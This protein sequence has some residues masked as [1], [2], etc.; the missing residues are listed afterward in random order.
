[1]LIKI[2]EGTSLDSLPTK[3]E[4][5]T[6]FLRY[7]YPDVYDRGDVTE[8]NGNKITVDFADTIREFTL[9]EVTLVYGGV[10]GEHLMSRAD[11][12]LLKDFRQTHQNVPQVESLEDLLNF[13]KWLG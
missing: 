7:L 11:G 12:T 1:V 10:H 9:D 2:C 3:I 6:V 4:P 5:G 13:D 8:V